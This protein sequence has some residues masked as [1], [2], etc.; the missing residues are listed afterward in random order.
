[1]LWLALPAIGWFAN[2]LLPKRMHPL[3]LFVVVGFVCYAVMTN[4]ILSEFEQYERELLQFDTS[5]DGVIDPSESTPATRDLEAKIANDTGRSCGPI[6]AVPITAIWVLV[7]FAA[8]Y[9]LE[10]VLTRE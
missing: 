9:G 6:F 2:L 1:M 8:L 4:S 5:G 3:V 7:T 10:W